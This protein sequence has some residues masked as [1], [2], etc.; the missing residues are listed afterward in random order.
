MDTTGN[1]TRKTSEL[2]RRFAPYFKKYKWV[3]VLDLFCASLTTEMCIRDR[4]H[5]WYAKENRSWLFV[6]PFSV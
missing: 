5:Q 2:I 6:H 1:A 3:L 4:V